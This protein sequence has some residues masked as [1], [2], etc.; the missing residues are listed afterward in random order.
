MWKIMSNGFLSQEEIDSLLS[1]TASVSFNE[2]IALSNLEQD[3]LGYVGN[4]SM[5]SASTT[6]S[7]IINQQVNITMPVVTMTTLRELKERFEI[8]RIALEARY[9]SGIVGASILVMKTTDA[10]AIA[11]L[12]MGGNGYVEETELSEAEISTVSEV[13]DL[14]NQSAAASM[15]TMFSR[16]VDISSS[17]SRIWRDSNSTLSEAIDENE[18]IVNISYRLAIGTLVDSHIM[19]LLPV[20]TAKKIVNIMTGKEEQK[21]G[22]VKAAASETNFYINNTIQEKTIERP[23]SAVEVHT[24]SFQPL[25]ESHIQDAPKNIDL[26]L[27]VPLG[28]SVVLGRTKK[29]IKE[30][31]TLGTGSLI[32]LDKLAEEPVEILVNGKRIAFGE[33]VVV[34]ENFGVR[35]TSIVSNSEKIKT[36]AK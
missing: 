10:G 12:M 5:G 24:A 35:I 20:G 18:P 25:S 34:D 11:N 3:L 30:I 15:V 19:Q 6:L 1:G 28:I 21:E 16:D 27:D 17:G 4:I 31:L 8:P 26:I 32:E 22:P 33:V 14:M 2:D 13:M 29:S 7:Q 36:L 23:Q 9:T